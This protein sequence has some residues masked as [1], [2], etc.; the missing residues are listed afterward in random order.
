[1]QCSD[2]KVEMDKGYHAF[3]HWVEGKPYTGLRFSKFIM[4]GKHIEKVVSYLCPKCK[5]IVF[6]SEK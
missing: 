5:R 6:Y 4:P 3:G 1:M 2:C